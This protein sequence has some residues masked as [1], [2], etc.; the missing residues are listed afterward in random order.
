[1]EKL[2]EKVKQTD[3][4]AAEADKLASEV[5]LANGTV[6]KLK[7]EMNAQKT[8]ILRLTEEV[9]AQRKKND[10]SIFCR[11]VAAESSGFS[12]IANES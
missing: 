3:K 12:P 9:E 8:E 4:L 2:I 10:V 1:M 5:K 11:G 7:S 6:E